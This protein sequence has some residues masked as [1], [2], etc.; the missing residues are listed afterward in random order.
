MAAGEDYE[1]RRGLVARA[2]AVRHVGRALGYAVIDVRHKL[3][4]EFSGWPARRSSSSRRR[5][6]RSPASVEYP[7]VAYLGDTAKANYSD[8]PYVANARAL[9]LEC[10]F[11]DPDHVS[12]A[13]AGKHVHVVD[14]PEMLEGMNNEQIILIHVTRR[15]NMHQAQKFLK[16]ALPKDMLERI[17]FLMSRK[18]IEED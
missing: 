1:I 6:S 10:T 11:F 12:R 4:E 8:L 18:D 13:R 5:A 9:L 17:T 7:L 16:E 15:T 14:L 3:K 2:F